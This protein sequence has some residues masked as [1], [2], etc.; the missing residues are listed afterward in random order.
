M[1][2][3]HDVKRFLRE[4]LQALRTAFRQDDL[5]LGILEQALHY[6]PVHAVIIDNEHPRLRCNEAL[7]ILLALCEPAA[8][9]LGKIPDAL[10]ADNPLRQQDGKGRSRAID[11]VHL[12][13]AAHEPDQPIGER[14]S[15]AC[16]FDIAVLVEVETD[17]ILEQLAHILLPDTDAGIA[18]HDLHLHSGMAGQPGRGPRL[19]QRRRRLYRERYL[20]LTGIFHRVV[21]NIDH[22]LAYAGRIAIK[23]CRQH[24]IDLHLK[25]QPLILGPDLH[26]VGDI[27]E[28]GAQIVLHRHNIHAAGLHLGKVE[29]IIDERKQCL[30]RP[31]NILRVFTDI[32]IRALAQDHFIHPHDRVD[33]RTDF[34]GHACEEITLGLVGLLRLLLG[35]PQLITLPGLLLR[36]EQ[37]ND[38][39]AEEHHEQPKHPDDEPDDGH[40]ASRRC[41]PWHKAHELPIELLDLSHENKTLPPRQACIIVECRG[42]CGIQHGPQAVK[43][44]VFLQGPQIFHILRLPDGIRQLQIAPLRRQ[45]SP[46]IAI[47]AGYLEIL[48]DLLLTVVTIE[49]IFDIF[50]MIHGHREQQPLALVVG[51]SRMPLEGTGN[52][53]PLTCGK[54]FPHQRLSMMRQ[55]AHAAAGKIHLRKLLQMLRIAFTINL[56]HFF[57]RCQFSR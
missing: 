36:I 49:H 46:A 55:Y 14:Q 44:P 28:H 15:E 5:H 42:R 17:K 4:P 25:G 30:A 10:A 34:M 35:L 38:A 1:I 12:D 33:W 54:R 27:T 16:T 8:M 29:N 9:L 53:G 47:K 22:N 18:H 20:T 39:D 11:A 19:Q 24:R 7:L 52:S 26:H 57:Q 41:I 43:S 32:E 51:C 40:E 56:S 48:F 21:Q 6:K 37:V 2:E 50:T 13:I 23:A 3:Q 31:L 45:H